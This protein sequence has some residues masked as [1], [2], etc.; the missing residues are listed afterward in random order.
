MSAVASSLEANSTN[1]ADETENLLEIMDQLLERAVNDTNPPGH[2]HSVDNMDIDDDGNL[3]YDHERDA[4]VC[5]SPACCPHP[6]VSNLVC[7]ASYV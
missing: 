2:N 3:R 1:Q 4:T 5:N 7:F 6:I